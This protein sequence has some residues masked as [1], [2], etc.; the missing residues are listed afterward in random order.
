MCYLHII[1]IVIYVQIHIL[2]LLHV[3]IQYNITNV[4]YYSEHT[5]DV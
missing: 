5:C 3:P 2:E 4:F 1:N